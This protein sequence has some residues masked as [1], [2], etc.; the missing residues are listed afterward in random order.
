MLDT[1]D[2]FNAYT[3]AA[4]IIIKRKQ[5]DLDR[6]ALG[7]PPKYRNFAI[8]DYGLITMNANYFPDKMVFYFNV[9]WHYH[10]NYFSHTALLPQD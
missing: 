2:V 4:H 3:V 8:D 5:L 1:N 9:R 10:D 6:Q 7:N